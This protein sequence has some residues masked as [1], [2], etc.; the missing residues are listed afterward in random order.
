LREAQANRVAELVQQRFSGDLFNK[1]NF[2]VLGDCCCCV[3][4]ETPFL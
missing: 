2:V 4:T 1:E 3:S